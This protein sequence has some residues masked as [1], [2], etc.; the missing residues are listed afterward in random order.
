MA[1]NWAFQVNDDGSSQG[2]NDP[3][4]AEFKSNRL[5]SLTREIIQNSLDASANEESQVVVEFRSVRIKSENIP[6]IEELREIVRLCVSKKEHQNNDLVKEFEIAKDI[7]NSDS[8]SVLKIS[9]MNTTGMPGPCILGKPFHQYLKTVGQSGGNYDR[10]GSHGIG[11]AAPLAC[12]DLRTI[13]VS[14]VWHDELVSR[15]LAQGRAVLMSFERNGRIHNSTG[16]WGDTDRFMPVEAHQIKS[17]HKWMLRNDVGTTISVLGWSY[18]DGEWESAVCGYAVSNFFAAFKRNKLK[19][20]VNDV[21]INLDNYRDILDDVAVENAIKKLKSGEKFD[22]SKFYAKCLWDTDAIELVIDTKG[23]GKV[24]VKIIL[25]EG[26]PR[27]VALIRNNMLITDL[28]P[29][30]WSRVPGRISDFAAVIEVIDSDGSKLIRQMEPPS[31]NNLSSDWLPTNEEKKRGKE[32]LDMLADRLKAIIDEHAGGTNENFG[33]IEF[34][35]EYFSD[36]D[37]NQEGGLEFEEIDPNSSYR[38]SMKP[39]KLKDFSQSTTIEEIEMGEDSE[40][41][42]KGLTGAGIAG[43]EGQTTYPGGSNP[44]LTPGSEGNRSGGDK[45]SIVATSPLELIKCRIVLRSEFN[46]VVYFNVNKS[47]KMSLKMMEVGSDYDEPVR[48]VNS[49]SGEV[50]NGELFLYATHLKREVI[51]VTLEREIVGGLKISAMGYKD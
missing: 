11:K 47:T 45:K 42:A 35:A 44:G 51:E 6:N 24:S 30:F 39:I 18:E 22:D 23:L 28:V 8:I 10:G 37:A 20:I 32:I 16:Y 14:T 5:E 15:N 12:S 17:E 41:D 19:V 27:K 26:S 43:G 7:V 9:D 46:A 1:I 3:S 49:L 4:I 33:K 13:F 21:E 29:G 50:K 31:H 40:E 36:S 38:V 48:I 34:M 2:W 25:D